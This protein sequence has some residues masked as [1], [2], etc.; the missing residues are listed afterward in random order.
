MEYKRKHVWSVADIRTFIIKLLK[1][2][3]KRFEKIGEGLQH[4]TAA[5]IVFF[6]H[7]FKKLLKL[8]D[9]IKKACENL[10]MRLQTQ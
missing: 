2:Q 1:D 9:E 8:K 3:P 5:E 10:K 4:K 6:Y 7:T